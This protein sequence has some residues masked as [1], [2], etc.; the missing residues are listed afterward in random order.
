M[1]KSMKKS[2]IKALLVLVFVA[3]GY[4]YTDHF[5]SS[6]QN[7]KNG[8]TTNVKQTINVDGDNL[9]IYFVDV[10]QADCILIN[11]NNE[12][13]LIDAGNN[14][15]GEKLVKYFKDLGVSGFKYVFGTHAHED[16]IGG[17]DDI[18]NN[19]NIE[20]FYMPDAITTTKTFE[21]VL[22]GNF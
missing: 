4:F 20:H 21:D 9:K 16:H 7:I 18:I 1:S 14:E 15:D 13:S 11:D 2:L 5:D 10:G 19:F 8:A 6:S 3:V 17:M 22:N 12:Y